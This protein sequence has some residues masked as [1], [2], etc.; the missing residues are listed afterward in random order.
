MMRELPIQI[1][2]VVI[3]LAVQ[4]SNQDSGSRAESLRRLDMATRAGTAPA[5]LDKPSYKSFLAPL[6]LIGVA[7]LLYMK[8]GTAVAAPGFTLTRFL[9]LAGILF[10][11][12][13]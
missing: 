9:E 7:I 12:G 2:Q 10:L 1:E 3:L 4:G 6:L 5:V 11:A 8:L 13:F